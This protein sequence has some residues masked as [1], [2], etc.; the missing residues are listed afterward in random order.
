MPDHHL[1]VDLD[2]LHEV[3]RL[4]IEATAP[5]GGPGPDVPLP[6]DEASDLADVRPLV[7][8]APGPVRRARDRRATTHPS[9]HVPERLPQT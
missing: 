3:E 7:P 5:P 6:A 9:A 8:R 2:V 1:H 4:L